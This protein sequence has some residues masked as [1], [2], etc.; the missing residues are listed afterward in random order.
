VIVQ[1]WRHTIAKRQG[2][3]NAEEKWRSSWL[4]F[5]I[6]QGRTFCLHSDIGLDFNWVGLTRIP[7]WVSVC[8]VHYIRF[9]ITLFS[10]YSSS[11]SCLG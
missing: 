8:F 6:S 10:A 7:A 3:D 2:R 9:T 4:C 1:F 5:D 11:I